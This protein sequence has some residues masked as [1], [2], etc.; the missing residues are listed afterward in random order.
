MVYLD[1]IAI[2]W[3]EG[4]TV[5]DL[6]DD[7][8]ADYHYAVVKL[9]GRLVSRPHFASTPVTDGSRIVPLPMIAGG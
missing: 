5:A 3:Q 7:V 9:D 1:D 2:A 4:M 8:A 6:L